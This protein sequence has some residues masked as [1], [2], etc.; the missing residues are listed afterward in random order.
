MELVDEKISWCAKDEELG[1][2]LPT[3]GM[4][5]TYR[6]MKALVDKILWERR[7][8]NVARENGPH[9]VRASAGT[10]YH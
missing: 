4:R 2:Q 3:L 6:T 8:I 7:L 1:N 9:S 5:K 10:D